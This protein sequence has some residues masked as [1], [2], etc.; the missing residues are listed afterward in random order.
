MTEMLD[1][2]KFDLI[3][4]GGGAAGIAAAIRSN[5]LKAKTA[6]INSGL[7]L[8]GTCVNVG[9][10]PSKTLLRAGEVLHLAKKHG[11]PGI[12]L[13]IKGFDFDKIIKDELQLVEKLRKVKYENALKYLE[14]C[15]V[16][17]GSAAFVSKNTIEVNGEHIAADKFIVAAGST[18]N[19]PPIDG[20]RET[21]FMTHTEA[22]KPVRQP[23]ELIVVG[24]GPLG[25]EY[26]QMYAR[27]GT[28]V[29]ILQRSESILPAGEPVLVERLHRL[30][31]EE[32]ITIKTA[33]RIKNARKENGRK[34]LVYL[35]KGQREEVS[36]D[37]ILLAAGKTPNTEGLALDKAGIEIDGKRAIGVND[38][39]QT[40]QPHIFAA[41]DVAALPLRLETTAGHEGTL[42][43]ENALRGS[44][45]S[46]DYTTVPYT[47]FTDPQFASVGFTE[48]QQMKNIGVC[49]CRTISFS[50]IPRA[51]I[52][53]RIEGMIKMAIHPQT[54][55]ILGVHVIAPDAGDIIAEAMLL[56]KNKNTIDDVVESL[57]VFPTLSEAIK[58]VALAFNKDVSKLSCCI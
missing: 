32:D 35:R 44:R 36:G 1:Q 18:A 11:V 34:Y 54:G 46:M 57:P 51:H 56:V 52:M 39:L 38:F 4:I 43:A 40:S 53:K 13:A 49:A 22:L 20:I 7:P 12:E 33:V 42:A 2:K 14:N 27:F 3:I 25:L 19:V 8:G 29:T 50:N 48:E 30:L 58:I 45:R 21:G 31:V 9:C 16:I 37:E 5:E 17:E 6:L 47:I 26:A 24:A 55:R 15:T 10:V 41:G 28:R 23:E